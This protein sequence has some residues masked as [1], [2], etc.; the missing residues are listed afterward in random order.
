MEHEYSS[1][2]KGNL[3]VTLGA[4]GTGLGVLNGGLGNILGSSGG[5]C[6]CSENHYVNRYEL[7]LQQEIAAKDTRIG[8]LE[9]NIYTDSKLASLYEAMRAENNSRFDRIECQI[10]QQNVINAQITANLS[11]MQNSINVLQGLTKTVIPITSVCPEPMPAYN[12]WTAPTAPAT[13]A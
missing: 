5:N 11:C 2:G 4:I 6:G 9:S 7:G 13:G 3:G 1:N 12:S 8:L 10:N